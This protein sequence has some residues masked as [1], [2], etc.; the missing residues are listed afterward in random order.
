VLVDEIE[1]IVKAGDGG[2]GLLAFRW[3]K[4]PK[5]GP[6]GGEGGNGGNVYAEGVS[7]IA[8]LGKYRFQKMFIAEN[9]Q[10]GL[11]QKGIGRWGQDLVLKLPVGSVITVKGFKQPMAEII[12]VGERILLARSGE[13][14]HG[15]WRFR[16][17]R[18]NYAENGKPGQEKHLKIE[19]RLIAD[20]GLIGLANAGKSSLLNELTR[21]SAKVAN[22][23]FTTLEPNL[24]VMGDYIL[25]DLPGLIEGAA[26]GKGLGHKFLRHVQRT[27]VL[28][29]CLSAES[30]NL[31]KDYDIIRSE[32]GKF[33]EEL[34]AKQEV[35]VLTKSDLLSEKGKKGKL[36][37]LKKLN[38]KVLI[39]SVHDLESLHAFQ[40]L[41]TKT[42]NG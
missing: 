42:L 24:G 15:N 8:A 25:A 19:L 7:D 26:A 14:G 4:P 13:G 40:T 27:R 10:K 12:K 38:P 11:S 1:I 18:P 29:H 36:K 35:L 28:V 31:K 21:A 5:S 34:L 2:N 3:N 23:P 39:I 20:I 22:Y 41:L 6:E 37:I 9:G 33:N 30:E 17:T 16:A 32:L